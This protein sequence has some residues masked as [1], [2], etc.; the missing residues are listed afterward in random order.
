M[1]D[2]VTRIT[3]QSYGNRVSAACGAIIFCPVFV[4]LG[5]WLLI[6][7]EGFSIKQHRA[8]TEGSKLV[9]DVTNVDVINPSLDHLPIH[10]TGLATTDSS[11]LVDPLFGVSPSSEGALKLQRHVE[12]YQWTESSHSETIKNPDG[13]TDTV[14]TY[15]YST[16]WEDQVISSDSFETSSGHEN[17]SGMR[18]DSATFTADT[19]HVGAY[20]LTQEV[21]SQMDWFQPISR[22]YLTT[23]EIPNQ[24]LQSETI[25]HHNYFYYCYSSPRW[26]HV[27]DTRVSFSQ[28]PSQVISVVAQ[29]S[30]GV[31]TSYRASNGNSFLLV[32]QGETNTEVMF[33][34]AHRAVSLQTWLLRL[35]GFVIIWIGFKSLLEP[36]AVSTSFIPCVGYLTERVTNSVSFLLG[37]C[38]SIL[39]IAVAWLAYRPVLSASLILLALC[40]GFCGMPHNDEEPPTNQTEKM[41]GWYDEIPTAQAVPVQDDYGRYDYDASGYQQ[42]ETSYSNITPI[43]VSHAM[44]YGATAPPRN[45]AFGATAPPS[46]ME[47]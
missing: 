30:N 24:E 7:N 2:T 33:E 28:V 47:K 1:S 5:S 21:L 42:R 12:M 11:P 19:I 38:V 16:E 10:F 22:E 8:L 18:F 15:T 32:E 43:P 35:L 17:P 4:Y 27:G 20:P 31:P 46:S 3:H 13:S 9:V 45:L 14:T 40:C 23:D 29:Q 34:H 44:S 25:L 26:P 6:W 37:F 39:I 41:G 36:L